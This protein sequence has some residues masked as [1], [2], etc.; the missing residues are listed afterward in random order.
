MLSVSPPN[1]PV[2]VV[3][4]AVQFFSYSSMNERHPR[5]SLSFWTLLKFTFCNPSCNFHETNQEI[6]RAPLDQNPTEEDKEDILAGFYFFLLSGIIWT[7]KELF[8]KYR[9][10][11]W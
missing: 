9:Q 3:A 1:V 8:G 5:S 11:F 6:I 10:P 7:Q 2:K 4:V